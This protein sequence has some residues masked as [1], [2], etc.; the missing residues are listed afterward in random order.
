MI[1]ILSLGFNVLKYK[2]DPTVRVWINDNFLDEFEV[3]TKE[4]STTNYY[5][6]SDGR[7]QD[8]ELVYSPNIISTMKV[9]PMMYKNSFIEF[10]EKEKPDILSKK[11]FLKF[12][13]IDLTN[14][15]DKVK[16]KI[17]VENNDSNY[18][19]G[20][21]SKT[22]LLC[23]SIC[24]LIPKELLINLVDFSKKFTISR[25]GK[26]SK[27]Y[28]TNDFQIA[29]FY[30]NRRR[31]FCN[32]TMYKTTEGFNSVKNSNWYGGRGSFVINF[33]KK[34]NIFTGQNPIPVGYPVFGDHTLLVGLRDKYLKY[35]NIRNIN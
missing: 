35:E 30:K 6:K 25:F 21:L 15:K 19:N 8:T 4:Y 14:F 12:Y 20:F 7:W 28:F 2:K 34:C 17:E 18:T 11:L 24:T 23:L 9:G 10:Y 31:L 3:H 29:K 33:F 5:G 22:T 13:E 27:K 1:H 26:Q 16:I 32:S